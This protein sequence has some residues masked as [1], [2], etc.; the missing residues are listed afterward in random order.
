MKTKLI[1]II[2]GVAA[3]FIGTVL[4]WTDSFVYGDRLSWVE[5]QGRTQVEAM[6]TS[7]TA[8]FKTV[9]RLALSLNPSQV[10]QGN[11][12]WSQLNPYFAVASL[13]FTSGQ[14]QVTSLVAKEDT[15]AH[16]WSKDFVKAAIGPLQERRRDMRFYVKPFQDAKK[17]RYVSVLVLNGNNAIALLGSGEIFQS[18]VDSQKGSFN[19]FSVVTLNGLTVAHTTPEYLGTVMREDPVYKWA[20]GL[21]AAHGSEV[22]QTRAGEMIGLF[23]VVPQTNLY[24]MSSASV[25]N[26]MAG[27]SQIFWQI[28]L[29]GTG[30][31]LVA[32]AGLYY[33]LDR[34]PI[35]K[36][37]LSGSDAQTTGE[38]LVQVPVASHSEEELP[39][40]LS[41]KNI[42]A[43]AD[44][45]EKLN[46]SVRVAS[47][48]AH[49]MA[50][51]LASILGHS[52]MIL[53]KE[54]EGDL[55]STTEAIVRE[56]RMARGVLDKLM[57]FTGEEIKSKTTMKVEGPLVK[58][59]KEYE[60]V[61]EQKGIK[62][63]KNFGKTQDLPLHSEALCKAFSHLIVNA[64]EA[65]ERRAEKIL[66][67]SLRQE[68][69]NV[70]VEISDTG[71]GIEVVN[72][73]KIFDPFFTTRA[74]QNHM[75]LG[76]S[77]AYGILKEH[78]AEVNAK[79]E[80]G[81]GTSF[82]IT[83]RPVA[84]EAKSLPQASLQD[85]QE[86]EEF[87]VSGNLPVLKPE[88]K[89]V[90]EAEFKKQN[91]QVV[92]PP[93]DVNIDELLSF[94]DEADE[95]TL[96]GFS[97]SEPEPI[98]LL[99][100]DKKSEEAQV[101][102]ET[103]E[104]QD[105][106]ETATVEE[107]VSEEVFTPQKGL[108]NLEDLFM[109]PLESKTTITERVEIVDSE[110]TEVLKAAATEALTKE[111]LESAEGSAAVSFVGLPKSAPQ[112]KVTKL[113]SYK[114]DIRRPGKGT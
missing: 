58:A 101:L 80:L 7:L 77:A 84:A 90:E 66:K 78:G 35:S 113:D 60:G 10:A 72:L 26:A 29:M 9:Y 28:V 32:G 111:E 79:S 108:T 95:A 43:E 57:G 16:G 65:M 92:A 48:L 14:V 94:E 34:L 70:V 103:D 87:I 47:A 110:K 1:A 18:F 85:S 100:E 41:A 38:D 89:E 61:F 109:N 107:I 75:G 63:E 68:Q 17:G 71:E 11:V 67:V 24:V 105:R 73:N 52:Q 83:F 4:W 3:L 5:S 42:H 31:L 97:E 99:D 51:P 39:S 6:N 37:S 112:K 40:V 45:E 96:V 53:A 91:A 33:W 74:F 21:E 64:V 102:E 20:A 23:E 49:E 36:K 12:N 114:V 59:L 8:E 106:L 54:P 76:L 22:L 13:D 88:A 93:V 86:P 19:S 27:R 98:L 56:A 69:E 30:L 50:R 2:G 25:A 81:A 15:A 46:A 44:K 62:L 104:V 82:T 55:Q